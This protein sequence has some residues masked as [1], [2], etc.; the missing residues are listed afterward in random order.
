M[1]LSLRP[2]VVRSCRVG[3]I[4]ALVCFN[5]GMIAHADDITLTAGGSF[6]TATGWSDGLAPH[7][8]G[9]YFTGG[10]NLTTD[11]STASFT[12][13]GDSLTVGT[14][15]GVF[16]IR[17]TA[18]VT[19]GDL[20]LNSGGIQN[21]I[22]YTPTLAGA[23]TLTGYGQI[24]PSQG[25]TLRVS[26]TIGGS[27]EL[28]AKSGIV[29]LTSANNY[30]GGTLVQA[31]TTYGSVLDVQHDGALGSGNVTLLLGGTSLKLSGG[32][33]NNYINDSASL[34]LATGIADSSISLSFVG[35]D[36]IGS[37]SFDGGNT[38]AANGTWGAVGSG[39]THTSSLFTG[40]GLLLVGASIPEPTTAGLLVGLGAFVVAIAR[41][42][43]MR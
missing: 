37:L 21:F 23:I 41:R 40:A 6:S 42:R 36:A 38:F 35:T 3:V 11:V 25:R 22:G 32:T 30:L 7:A 13:G 34:I 10:Y 8:G 20:R 29:V 16:A 39:A 2:L 12:F 24:N 15:G 43:R 33:T 1:K 31:D 19:V 4:A 26:A 14:G 18:T 27:G 5:A 9:A 28:R 17:T